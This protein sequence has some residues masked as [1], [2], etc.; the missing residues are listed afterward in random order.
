MSNKT[1]NTV[2]DTSLPTAESAIEEAL[3][4]TIAPEIE[5]SVV[6]NPDPTGKDP[7]IRNN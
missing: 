3:P 4:E 6:R 1:R 5:R 2:E 7:T